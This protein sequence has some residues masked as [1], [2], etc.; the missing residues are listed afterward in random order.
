MVCRGFLTGNDFVYV[1]SQVR[2]K[3]IRNGVADTFCNNTDKAAVEATM[4]LLPMPAL[5]QAEM[6]RVTATAA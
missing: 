3:E 4:P 6:E 2:A 1:G 5:G